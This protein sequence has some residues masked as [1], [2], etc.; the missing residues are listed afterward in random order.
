MSFLTSCCDLPQKE[1]YRVF[2]ADEPFFSAI[3][4]AFQDES[5]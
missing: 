4:A 1:Q 2:S 3:G 5:K